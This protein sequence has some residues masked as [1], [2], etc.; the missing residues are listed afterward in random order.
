MNQ[1]TRSIF[2]VAMSI[3]LLL[4]ATSSAKD[5]PWF[6]YENAN[7]DAYSDSSEKKVR[8]LLEELENFR[9]AAEQHLTFDIPAGA[10]KTQVV[11]LNSEK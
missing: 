8:K 6:R 2:A 11:I 5:R 4:S 10:V 7:F 9:A 3:L 1:V